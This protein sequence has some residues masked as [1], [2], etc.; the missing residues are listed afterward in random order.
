LTAGIIFLY[1]VDDSMGRMTGSPLEFQS[2]AEWRAWLRSNGSKEKEAWLLF[3]KRDAGESGLTY[4]QALDE[5][6]CYGWIDSRMRRIDEIKHEIRF[7]PRKRGSIWSK[8]NLVRVARLDEKG[9]MTKAGLD[10]LPPD[11]DQRMEEIKE[12]RDRELEVPEAL[13][14]ALSKVP[15]ARKNF[16]AMAPTHRRQFIYWIN[17]G[18]RADT[19]DKRISESISLLE[20]NKTLIDR[21]MANRAKPRER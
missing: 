1:A 16:Y 9:R 4:S 14:R 2:A 6:I 12:G 17:E 5:A 19:R 11:F 8:H 3:Y 18:K 10:V 15:Q 20:Q 7:T 21:W 13:E